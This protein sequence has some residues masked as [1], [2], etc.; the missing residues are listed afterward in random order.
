[1]HDGLPEAT[2]PTVWDGFGATLIHDLGKVAELTAVFRKLQARSSAKGRT[3]SHTDLRE[4][5]SE[6]FNGFGIAGSPQIPDVW[7]GL[8]KKQLRSSES[9]SGQG[10]NIQ[11]AL[12]LADRISKQIQGEAYSRLEPGEW[13]NAHPDARDA[14]RREKL[15]TRF[16]SY[17]KDPKLWGAEEV[18]RT[19][20][21]ICCALAEK[22][23]VGALV[24]L[25]TAISEFPHTRY[26]PHLSL[27]LHD[28]FAASLFYFIYR[29]LRAAGDSGSL[30]EFAFYSFQ[31]SPDL[32][33]VFYR[34][35]DILACGKQ[36]K[37]FYKYVF[38]ELFTPW[39]SDLP[40]ITAQHNPFVFYNREGFVFLYPD[41]ELA[42]SGLER[43]LH[44]VPLLRKIDIRCTRFAVDIREHGRLISSTESFDESLP[45]PSLLDFVP[46]GGRRCEACQRVA[47]PT[48]L[49][50]DDKGAMLCDACRANRR[51]S[52]GID[53]DLVGTAGTGSDRIA[54][55]F[56][57][58]P[59]NL[60]SHAAQVAETK[61]IPDFWQQHELP[62]AYCLPATEQHIYE[63]LQALLAIREFDAA[64]E[65]GV[66]VIRR[67]SGQSAALVL[68]QNPTSKA[69][70]THEDYLWELLDFV[71]G[72]KQKLRLECSVRAVLCAPRTPFWSLVE[73]AT[74]HRKGDVLWDVSREAIHM[75]SDTEITSIRRLAAEAKKYRILRS[76]LNYLSAVALQTSLEEL[77]LEVDNRTDRLKELRDPIKQAVRALTSEGSTLKDQ[78]KRAVFFKY[79]AGLTR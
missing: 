19:C 28:L 46:E 4:I 31:V 15:E 58:I 69:L 35:R 7:Y 10:A 30:G 39:E 26:V 32:L 11:T 29:A 40:G 21:R 68:F 78:E 1:M 70:V 62:M 79:V 45:A 34:L 42:R 13:L 53:L 66:E 55:V 36:A 12:S 74:Q 75:F 33:D 72:Q 20:Q 64:L 48:E 6:C 73:L 27:Q 23:T 67:E 59:S 60:R 24:E 54:Y 8:I 18:N 50:E 9:P 5:I 44:A 57:T 22:P 76:Q 71:H 51:E 49:S 65:E 43:A 17:W 47:A 14:L 41:F 52:S 16:Y 77:I 56:V 25:Q 61:L 3:L 2:V 38:R 63:Y 37:E